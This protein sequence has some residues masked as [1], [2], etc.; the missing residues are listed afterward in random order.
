MRAVLVAVVLA[1]LLLV[2]FIL[3]RGTINQLRANNSS[4]S[5]RVGQLSRELAEANQSRTSQNTNQSANLPRE[6]LLELMRLRAEV[7]ELR[8]RT[9]SPATA[10]NIAV[11]TAPTI[12]PP[13]NPV[14]AGVSAATEQGTNSVV[15]PPWRNAG[16][17]QPAEAANT[18]L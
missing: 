11:R 15:A 12:P 7:G 17:A 16:F 6:Q 2:P 14:A 18:F 4:L 13:T 10:T 9:N 8:R 1:G 3:Q 5:A